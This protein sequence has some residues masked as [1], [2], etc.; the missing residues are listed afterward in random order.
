MATWIGK[1]KGGRI[2]QGPHE[3]A[4]FVIERTVQGKGRIALTLDSQSEAEAMAELAL[5]NRDPAGYATKAQAA[6]VA[7][8]AAVELNDATVERFLKHLRKKDRSEKYIRSTQGY[9]AW[10]A[11]RLAGID[12]RTVPPRRYRALLD[13]GEH[14]GLHLRIAAIKSFCSY[15]RKDDNEVELT[16]AQDG[17]LELKV[18]QAKPAKDRAAKGY[19][20]ADVERLYRFID[21]QIVRD[22]YRAVVMCGM[23]ST[24]ARR[25]IDLGEISELRDAASEIAGTLRFRHKNRGYHIQSVDR[26]TLAATQRLKAMG[27]AM[28]PGERQVNN[29]L[30]AAQKAAHLSG[31]ETGKI[32]LGPMRHSFVTWARSAGGRIVTPPVGG[33][34]LAAVAEA[35]GHR[36]KRTTQLFY[37][38][39]EVP[40]MVVVPVTLT[41]PNDPAAIE[42]AHVST[43]T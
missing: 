19:A 29:A 18:P 35:I 24:E 4:R 14:G 30:D 22:F 23:H 32:R 36:D 16:T 28:I 43:G 27:A 7:Q 42:R 40:P 15:L 26:L 34:S 11:E 25:L 33:V 20:I 1:W 5:F 2:R 17:T 6:D 3:T 8:T 37:D 39:T 12:L 21:E 41:H 9:L 10:W 31:I 38:G 13:A